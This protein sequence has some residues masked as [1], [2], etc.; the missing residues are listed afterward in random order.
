MKSLKEYIEKNQFLILVLVVMAIGALWRVYGLNTFNGYATIELNQLRLA[1]ETISNGFKIVAVNLPQAAFIMYTSIIG[2]LSGFAPIYFRFSQALV[3]MA[4]VAFFYLFVKTWFNKQVAL[5]S[6]LFFATNAYMVILSRAIDSSGMLLLLQL[7][8]LYLLTI[9]FREKN[10]YLFALCGALGGLGFYLSPFFLISSLFIF[11]AALAVV[12]KNKKIFS[13]Y[14]KEIIAFFLSMLVVA[15]YY[16]YSLPGIFPELIRYFNPGAISIFYLNLGANVLA[17]FNHA[18]FNTILNVG[19]EPVVDPFVSVSFFCGLVYAMFHSNKR[20]Y[21]FLILW[22]LGSLVAI[23]LASVQQLGNLVL[24]MPAIFIFSAT[25]LD[26]ILTNWTKTFPYNKSAKLAM[27]LV[28]SLFL[29]LSVYYNYQKFFYGWQE[30]D[31]IKNQF[32]QEFVPKL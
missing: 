22:L 14:K 6:S 28:F 29:F 3:G 23:S 12:Q 25:V 20:K 31:L 9:S 19:L 11:V 1:S 7:L 4:A 10:I 24:L 8:I 27:T 17:I 26:Y 30:N 5:I 2:K 18:Q 15:S 13:L 16:L 32:K 21:L